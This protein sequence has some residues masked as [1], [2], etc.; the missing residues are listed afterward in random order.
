MPVKRGEVKVRG[1]KVN[2]GFSLK[3]PI[4]SHRKKVEFQSKYHPLNRGGIGEEF[5]ALMHKGEAH[6]DRI[7]VHPEKKE[8]VDVVTQRKGL[9]EYETKISHV[10]FNEKTGEYEKIKEDILGVSPSVDSAREFHMSAVD[11][12]LKSKKFEEILDKIRKKHTKMMSK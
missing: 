3:G 2:E 5:R 11:T 10:R 1:I 7:L 12:L 4:G 8:F 6:Y 9:A